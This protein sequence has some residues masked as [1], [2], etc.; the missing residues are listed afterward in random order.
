MAFTLYSS[1]ILHGWP[2]SLQA[3]SYAAAVIVQGPKSPLLQCA[4][5]STT[6]FRTG[7]LQSRAGLSHLSRMVPGPSAM[8]RRLTGWMGGVARYHCLH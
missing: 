7:P 3:G 5:L 8:L 6:K 2:V 4:R 1:G